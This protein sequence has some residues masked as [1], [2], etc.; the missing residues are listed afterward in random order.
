MSKVAIFCEGESDMKFLKDFIEYIG[1]K[2]NKVRPYVMGGKSFF[3]AGKQEKFDTLKDEIDAEVVERVLFIMDA[4]KIDPNN[5]SHNGFHNTKRDLEGLIVKLGLKEV[6]DFY[7]MCDPNTKEGSLESLILSTIN[8]KN[9][10]GCIIG[11][12]KCSQLSS[13]EDHKAILNQIYKVVYPNEPY[14]FDHHHFNDL[15]TQ[16]TQLF[17]ESE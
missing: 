7:I 17:A 5:K 13:K 15:K 10:R 6:S 8:D 2:K 16:L 12:L 1:G 3:F 4:D 11:F 9:L 14:N